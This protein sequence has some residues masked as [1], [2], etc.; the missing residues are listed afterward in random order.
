MSELITVPSTLIESIRNQ[1]VVLF[2]GAG[3]SRE[4]LNKTAAHPPSAEQLRGFLGE[5]FFRR[6]MDQYDLGLLA[7]MAIQD[8]GQAIVFEYVRDLLSEF[9]PSA[10]HFRVPLFR[11]RAIATTN[12]DILLENAYARTSDRLQNIVPL[13]KDSEPVEGRMQRASDP[14]LYLKLHGCLNHE[15]C[16]NLV[17]GG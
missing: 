5:K 4:S 10:A 1:R 17:Y 12:Y 13:V 6:A 3:A 9:E 15:L 16:S 2:L 7:E 11:W 8:H 14:L